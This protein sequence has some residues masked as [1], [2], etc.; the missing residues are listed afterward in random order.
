MILLLTNADTELL[1]VRSIL[2]RLPAGFP[3]VRAANPAVGG[4]VVQP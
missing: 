4:D 1:A 2:H 3:G